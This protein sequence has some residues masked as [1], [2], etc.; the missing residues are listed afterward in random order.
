M[1]DR[2]TLHCA[3]YTRKSTEEG[4]DQDFNSL[5]AQSEAC[6]AYILSQASEGWEAEKEHYDDGGWS[7][8]SMDRPALQQ[9][10]SDIKAGK[11]DIVV[12]YKVDRLTRSLAD[13]AKIV[14]ILDQ[15]DASFV[16]VTQSF[17]TT[18]SM[19][20]LTLNVLLSFAQFEREVTSERIRDKIAASKKK[21]M[22]MGGAVPHGYKV[23]DRKLLIRESEAEDVRHIFSSY[24]ELRSIPKLADHLAREGFRTRKRLLKDGRTIGGM[25]FGTGPLALLL[26]NP[27]YIGKIRH[28]NQVYEGEHQAIIT[29][30]IF[31]EVQSTLKKNCRDKALGKKSKYPS[32]LTGMITDP[33]GRPMS[34]AAGKKGTKRYS[35]Y[36]TR[37]G[38]GE[39]G[40]SRWRLPAGEIDHL[41]IDTITQHLRSYVQ[42]E[43]TCPDKLAA[44]RKQYANWAKQLPELTVPGKRKLLIAWKTRVELKENGISLS[45]QLD[46]DEPIHTIAVDAKL[47]RKGNELKLALSPDGG[48][49]KR[50]TDPNLL[51]LIA[52]A[53][54]AREHLIDGTPSPLVAHNSKQHLSKLARLSY[55]APA[56]VTAITIGSQPPQITAR[57]LLRNGNISLD[58]NEQRKQLGFA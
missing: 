1:V 57:S 13:F 33:K 44:R 35:Y 39:V 14:E 8:G 37:L 52:L 18:T 19:G 10:L 45:L 51:K 25:C 7:G 11:V 3:I 53:F 22:W 50:F 17:N 54:A 20:R 31:E 58:W 5:D 43:E 49:A 4:L 32:L 29:D 40:A 6:S 28:K 47:V 2:K 23:E 15:N 21:G 30:E 46:I 12:V 56:I 48:S 9:V 26:K 41:V 42:P 55:L 34:P 38:P 16:S 24:L 27:I 36:V